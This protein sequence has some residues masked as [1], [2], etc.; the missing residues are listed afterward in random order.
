MRKYNILVI[1]DTRSI[2]EEIR[3]ILS[4][5]GM[6]VFTAEN[7]QEGI[8]KAKEHIPDLILCDIMMPVKDGFEVF[9]EIQNINKLK[10]TPFIF[11][12]AKAT[13][14]NRREGMILGADD[15]IAKPFDIDLLIRSI[16]SRLYKEKKRKEAEKNKLENLQ[17]NI[18]FAIPHELLTPLSAIIGISSLMKDPDIEIEE[19]E[20]R[21]LALGIFDSSQLLLST[22]QK[23]IYYTEVELLINNDKKKTLLKKEITKEGQNELEE[24]SQII[25]KKFNRKSDIELHLKP[26]KIKIS[27]YH[28]EVVISNIV[29]N[30]FKFSNKGDKVIVSVKKDDSHAHITVS[31][32]GVGFDKVSLTQIGAFNQFNR[33]EMDQQGMGLGLIISKKLINFYGGKLSISKNKPKGSCVKLS[34]LIA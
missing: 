18:S 15:Y 28:F 25:V 2:R 3:D 10:H 8:D 26:F 7:G 31:D 33:I 13:I 12:T 29:D 23:F 19:K 30:A 4:F 32:N 21:D 11:L 14:K 9:D 16:K 5:E 17:Y 6:Q 27:S 24:Q 34:F 20:I 1:E 22:L